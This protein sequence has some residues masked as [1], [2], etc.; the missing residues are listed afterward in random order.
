MIES[1]TRENNTHKNRRTRKTNVQE[2]PVRLQEQ[3]RTRK[4]YVREKRPTIKHI[5]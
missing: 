3:Q 1:R 5:V 2:K 4:K